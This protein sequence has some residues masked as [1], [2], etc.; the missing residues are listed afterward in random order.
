MHYNPEV[1]T[2][3]IHGLGDCGCQKDQNAR[4]SSIDQMAFG[5]CNKHGARG[6]S[7]APMRWI[8][9]NREWTPRDRVLPDGEEPPIAAHLVAPRLLYSHHGIYVA[10][11][12]VIH[13]SGL[14]SGFR[15][16]PVE[17]VS[18]ETFARGG[19]VRVRRERLLFGRN[20][21]VRRARA[22]LGENQYR[23][24]SNNCKHFCTWCLR[25]PADEGEPRGQMRAS[26]GQNLTRQVVAIIDRACSTA[27]RLSPVP[28]LAIS[29]LFQAGR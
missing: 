8:S 23:L 10:R 6:R 27:R 4:G 12:R 1:S 5:T 14:S 29:T 2:A 25:G 20:E 16:G 17:E 11:G 18:L 24:F 7:V 28:P 15:T 21:V 22:R 13:Y 19:V 9:T 26:I 3:K